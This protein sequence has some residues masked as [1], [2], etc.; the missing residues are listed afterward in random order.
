MEK[1]IITDLNTLCANCGFFN[2]GSP[3]NS[4]YGCNH[5]DAGEYEYINNQGDC[6]KNERD[7]IAISLT[8]R[9]IKCN[10]RLAKKFIKRALGLNDEERHTAIE[11]T[12][13]KFY[14]K[15]YSFSCPIS[16][17]VS[18]DS[19][20]DYENASEYDW[21]ESEDQMPYGWGDE[22]MSVTESEAEQ[23]NINY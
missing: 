19:I 8:K 4:G 23:M 3:V 17:E 16:Y 21:I 2:Q 22:L 15:C 10:R 6:V 9:N 13:Y 20:N 14:G 5:P 7:H 18:F 11:K 1:L 12:G